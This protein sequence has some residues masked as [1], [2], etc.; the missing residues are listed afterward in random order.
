MLFM[1]QEMPIDVTTDVIELTRFKERIV[2]SLTDVDNLSGLDFL[3]SS[4]Q[5]TKHIVP[6]D[7]TDRCIDLSYIKLGYFIDGKLANQRVIQTPA[8]F[9]FYLKQP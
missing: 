6:C 4:G 1:S 7:V 5:H 3:H 9:Q 2:V 8:D